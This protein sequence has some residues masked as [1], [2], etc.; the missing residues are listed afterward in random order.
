[1]SWLD[2]DLHFDFVCTFGSI[3]HINKL[4]SKPFQCSFCCVPWVFEKYLGELLSRNL[5]NLWFVFLKKTN[6]Q[7][8]PSIFPSTLT[9]FF[10]PTTIFYRR[11]VM[12]VSVVYSQKVSFRCHL[13]RVA[14]STYLLAFYTTFGNVC[15]QAGFLCLSL[16]K[17]LLFCLHSF[18]NVMFVGW[19][20]STCPGNKFSHLSCTSL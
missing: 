1:M 9:R 10:V 2:L 3:W 6:Q 11:C 7:L 20:A 5:C 15:L 17:E 18:L 4:R 8:A 19:R 12:V 13:T 14:S 16:I